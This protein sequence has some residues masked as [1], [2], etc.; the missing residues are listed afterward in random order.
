MNNQKMMFNKSLAK[1][2]LM[3]ISAILLVSCATTPPKL[4]PSTIEPSANYLKKV[5][6]RVV[7]VL[8]SGGAKG[9]SHLGVLKVLER[10]H[11]PVDMIVGTSAGSI[12]GALYADQPSADKIEQLLLTAKREE[13]IDF[14]Y[15]NIAS[16]VVSGV[17]LQNF[18]I[19]HMQAKT[20]EQLKIPFIAVAT[21]LESGMP[22]FFR[23]GLIAPAV[24][25]SSAIPPFFRPVNLY[26]NTYI[27]GGFI[28]PVAVDVAKLFHPKLIIAVELDNPLSRTLPTFSP[29][30]FIRGV[31]IMSMKVERSSARDAN[32]IIR[33][34]MGRISLFQETERK[35][36]IAAGER[37]ALKA[38]PTIKKLLQEN[39]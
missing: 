2:L 21:N 39:R 14:S 1:S 5:H 4:L 35:D 23:S 31:E 8:G 15:F 28:D 3:I 29:S 9:F 12:V 38:L 18:L 24:N 11:V 17:G 30:V 13:V 10:N 33:P 26:G 36:I 25:A 22:H 32:V 37:A 16:G 7:L 19:D 20:F 34:E 27:D 6:P